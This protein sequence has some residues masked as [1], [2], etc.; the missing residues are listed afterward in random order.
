MTKDPRNQMSLADWSTGGKFTDDAYPYQDAVFWA[1]RPFESKSLIAANSYDLQWK[2]IGDYWSDRTL[3]GPSGVVPGDVAQGDL[4]NCW[5]MAA[6]SA[7]AEYPSRVHD[8]FH[9]TEKS[10][11]G[12]YG[13]N[14]YSLG[15]PTTVWIDD[16]IAFKSNEWTGETGLFY[17]QVGADNAL[18]GAL[19]EK[20]LA[21]SV[22][23]LW[24]LDTGINADG[25]SMLNGSPYDE[26]RHWD[27]ATRP[28]LDEYW[29]LL[30]QHDKVKNIITVKS[31]P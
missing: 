5:L 26:V 21:K 1:D 10:P 22:G 8:L 7:Y 6:L 28:T 13:I 15:V 31:S 3:W 2:R 24:H 19:I 14:M 27:P 9:N 20:A 16:Y 23:N 17:A 18:W 25:I 11:S 29:E 30:R 4:G 12:L